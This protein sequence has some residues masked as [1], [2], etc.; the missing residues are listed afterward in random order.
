MKAVARLGRTSSQEGKLDPK[1]VQET[2]EAVAH[3]VAI[4][5]GFRVDRLRIVA[6]A[7]VREAEN[8]AEFIEQ[9]EQRTGCPVEVISA[10]AEAAL[11]FRSVCVEVDLAETTSATVGIGGG[12]TELIRQ[13]T[14]RGKVR[15]LLS[16]LRFSLIHAT[17]FAD[18]LE[19][20]ILPSLQADGPVFA[21]RYVYT[22]FARDVAR[23]M[24]RECIRRPYRFA[25]KPTVAIYFRL[26]LDE[27]LSRILLGR[28]GLKY[29]E[30]GMDMGFSSADPARKFP[31]LPGPDLRGMRGHRPR[32]EPHGDRRT[33]PIADQSAQFRDLVRPYLEHVIKV[34]AADRSDIPRRHNLVGRYL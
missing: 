27:A 19:G 33:L 14:V 1:A 8:R 11:A 6:T 20:E 5:R 12:S 23:G 13:T 18:R 15:R 28:H 24:D 16:P 10:E 29:H 34:P 17:D 2:T 21:D 25:P 22:A 3:M 26:S 31:D 30:A 32:A 7:A 4:A 9:L